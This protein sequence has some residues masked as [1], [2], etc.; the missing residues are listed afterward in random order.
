ML[1]VIFLKWLFK[2]INVNIDEDNKHDSFLFPNIINNCSN[3]NI[4][5]LLM[6]SILIVLSKK[7]FI[8]ISVKEISN[9]LIEKTIK[10]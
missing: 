6:F 10:W 2:I 5:I 1:I 9:Q 8:L 3:K 4:K 7:Y